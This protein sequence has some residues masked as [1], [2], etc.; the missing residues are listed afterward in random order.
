[1]LAIIPYYKVFNLSI[2]MMCMKGYVEGWKWALVKNYKK[3]ELN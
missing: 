1:M 3:N 2:L